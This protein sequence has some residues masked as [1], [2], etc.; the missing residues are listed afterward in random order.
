MTTA[1]ILHIIR[2]ILMLSGSSIAAS[3][4]PLEDLESTSGVVA[5]AI[6]A[7]WSLY[8]GVKARK[9]ATEDNPGSGA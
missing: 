5:A 9:Q 6:G 2:L 7:I 4:I 8:S 3:G 1:T